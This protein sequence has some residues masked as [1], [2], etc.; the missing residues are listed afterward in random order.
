MEIMLQFVFKDGVRNGMP[1]TLLG[2]GDSA[3]IPLVGDHVAF[4]SD[5]SW[6]VL[7][8]YFDFEAKPV[9]VT[10]MLGR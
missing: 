9:K 4:E 2:P 1:Q 8:R 10:L 7:E 3:L 5:G 6:K